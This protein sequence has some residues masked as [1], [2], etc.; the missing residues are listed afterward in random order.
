MLGHEEFEQKNFF[1][2]REFKKEFQKICN[3]IQTTIRCNILKASSD[4]ILV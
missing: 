1:F 2:I 3:E 4:A